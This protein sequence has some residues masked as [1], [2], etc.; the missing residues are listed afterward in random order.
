MEEDVKLAKHEDQPDVIAQIATELQHAPCQSSCQGA[1]H[2]GELRQ[3][4][5][6]G[7]EEVGVEEGEVVRGEV[8]RQRHA[9]GGSR[10]QQRR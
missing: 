7:D 10:Y 5:E 2:K 3:H 9:D 1:Q 6:G 8:A 4:H